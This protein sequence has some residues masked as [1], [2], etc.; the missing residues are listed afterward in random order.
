MFVFVTVIVVNMRRDDALAH[1]IETGRHTL[2]DVR[3][4]D[5]KAQLQI[6]QMRVC[7]EMMQRTWRTKL[8]GRIFQR[9][10]HTAGGPR[11]AR[12]D[13]ANRVASTAPALLGSPTYSNRQHRMCNREQSSRSGSKDRYSGT[14]TRTEQSSWP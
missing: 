5:V 9:D 1:R 6:M 13:P 11:G 12:R 10:G 14:N 7:D 2:F 8:V 4:T 3:V